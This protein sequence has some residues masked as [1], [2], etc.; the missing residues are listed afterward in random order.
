[1]YSASIVG[2][3]FLRS[4]SLILAALPTN[5]DFQVIYQKCEP[6]IRNNLP[7]SLLKEIA[8]PGFLCQTHRCGI[9]TNS[10]SRDYGEEVLDLYPTPIF[11][12]NLSPCHY[13]DAMAMVAAFEYFGC[14]LKS[15]SMH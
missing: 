7:S 6:C 15:F 2:F 13:K 5:L 8:F 9:K 3:G 11:P 14:V 12:F 1:L 4:S 10:G